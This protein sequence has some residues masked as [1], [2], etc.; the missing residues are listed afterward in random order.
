MDSQI[1]FLSTKKA[2]LIIMRSDHRQIMKKL[3]IPYREEILSHLIL[4]LS[5]VTIP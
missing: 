1:I 2:R 4:L 3:K 5:G